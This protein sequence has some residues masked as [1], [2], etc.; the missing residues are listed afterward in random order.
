MHWFRRPPYLR[1][2]LA[3]LIFAAVAFTELRGPA[4][5]HHPFLAEPVA[6][7]APLSRAALEW[8][9]V[10]RGL[11][12]AVEPDGRAAARALAAGEPL[13]PSSLDAG[14]GVPDGWWSVPV[15]LAPGTAPG[16]EVRLVVLGPEGAALDTVPGLVV[17][18]A[19]EDPF[20][21]AAPGLVAVAGDV[22]SAV[23]AASARDRVVV[24][25]ATPSASGRN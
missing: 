25:L 18:P 15:A 10:P 5:V 2:A 20:G 9:Q 14:A 3:A 1:W 17:A 21:A 7:G 22:A 19:G 24:L 23:A 4:T 12:P 11:L 6:A 13:L 8:R 16:T